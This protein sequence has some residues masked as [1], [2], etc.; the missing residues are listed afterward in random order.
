MSSNTTATSSIQLEVLPAT[1]TASAPA[2]PTTP[3]LSTGST[4]S[5]TATPTLTTLTWSTA[6]TST[7]SSLQN[8]HPFRLAQFIRYGQVRRTFGCS[9]AKRAYAC[10]RPA[11][12]HRF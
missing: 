3:P 10:T 9:A 11:V 8:L 6:S 12:L 1:S 7:T 4:T 2:Q 5:L